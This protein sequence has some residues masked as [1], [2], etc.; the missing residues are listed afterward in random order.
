MTD[1]QPI[2]LPNID[3]SQLQAIDRQA[4]A[5]PNDP[6]HPPRILV[7]YGSIRERSYSRLLSE[8]A[9]RLLR[10]FGCEVKSFDPRDLPLPDGLITPR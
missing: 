3:L 5:G 8:E 1:P 4:L 7:L 9:G 10:W 6:R 2:D